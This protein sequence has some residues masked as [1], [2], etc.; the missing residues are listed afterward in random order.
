MTG[1]S[2]VL[3]LLRS[4]GSIV[5]NKR[6]AKEIGLLEAIIYSELASLYKYWE[7]RGEL[8]DEEW[9]FCTFANLEE[10]TT[11]KERTARKHINQLEKLGLIESKLQGLP[12]KKYYRITDGIFE[13]LGLMPNKVGKNC[14]PDNNGGSEAIIA[15]KPRSNKVGKNYRTRSAKSSELDRQKLPGNNTRTNNTNFNN[16]IERENIIKN[17]EIDEDVKMY[18]SKRIDEF[19]TQGIDLQ[20]VLN[21]IEDNKDFYNY[22]EFTTGVNQL[23]TFPQTIEFPLQFLDHTFSDI[24]HY[25]EAEKKKLMKKADKQLSAKKQLEKATA[26]TEVTAKKVQFYNWLEDRN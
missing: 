8:T 18:I 22:V 17:A 13:V 21:W 23:L 2:N 3:D 25:V 6:L 19:E 7:G 10:N 5:V 16:K 14:L 1:V 15:E 9:F 26:I 20:T 24:D 4:D 12:S 11:I